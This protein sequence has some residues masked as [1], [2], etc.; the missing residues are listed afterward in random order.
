MSDVGLYLLAF[1]GA[2]VVLQEI[3]HVLSRGLGSLIRTLHD[4]QKG[5]YPVK[6]SGPLSLH[7]A[8]P[9]S[10]QQPPE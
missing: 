6:D 3:L 5:R 4:K 9:A 2:L 10:N 1:I 8:G 7:D